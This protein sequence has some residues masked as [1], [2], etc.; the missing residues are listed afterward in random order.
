MLLPLHHLDLHLLLLDPGLHVG[1]LEGV[2]HLRLSLGCV[3]LGVVSGFLQFKV[4]LGL[5]DLRVILQLGLHPLL[6]RQGLGDG[7]VTLGLGLADERVLLDVGS[8]SLAKTRQVS[9]I[10][11]DVL[12][13]VG[14]DRNT[15]V[16]QISRG[17]LE[18]PLGECFP[19]SVDFL[20]CHV[21]H[22]G[23]LMA[24]HG[25]QTD[26]VNLIMV[27]SS[28]LLRR[29]LQ[30]VLLLPVDLDLG[31][32]DHA[33][34]DALLG[35]HPGTGH[36]QGHHGQRDPQHVLDAGEDDGPT[37]GD[38]GGLPPLT[39]PGDHHHLVRTTCHYSDLKTHFV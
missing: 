27:L 12:Q 25:L 13:G 6:L 16:V 37:S 28:E 23:S 4:S 17:H 14:D 3:H 20:D 36:L 18:D 19:I 34:G 39:H 29:H 8:L 30:H 33:D 31:G 35:V 15:H 5:G 10:I 22:D 2:G 24:L 26:S 38:E 11:P 9:N 32:A 21:A 7:G 1:G